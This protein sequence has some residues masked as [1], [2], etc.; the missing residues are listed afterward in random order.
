MVPTIDAFRAKGWYITEK[1]LELIKEQLGQQDGTL[2]DYLRVALDASVPLDLRQLNEAGIPK[3]D[4]SEFPCP[5][6]LQIADVRNVAVPAAHQVEKPRLLRITFTDGKRKFHGVELGPIDLKLHTPPGTK[7][8]VTQPIPIRDQLLLLLPGV[9]QP[10]GGHVQEMIQAW[11][12]GKQFIKRAHENIE[13]PPL[14]V[15]FKIEIKAKEKETAEI[16]QQPKNLPEK[17]LQKHGKKHRKEDTAQHK[18]KEEKAKRSSERD[19]DVHRSNTAS[20]GPQVIKEDQLRS[21]QKT[22][23][24]HKASKPQSKEEQTMP[25]QA[26]VTASMSMSASDRPPSRRKKTSKLITDNDKANNNEKNEPA[27][28]T[29]KNR[30]PKGPKKKEDRATDQRGQ[31]PVHTGENSQ[32]KE[33]KHHLTPREKHPQAGDRKGSKTPRDLSSK[34]KNRETERPNN[35]CSGLENERQ[36]KNAT[37][38]GRPFY[39]NRRGHKPKGDISEHQQKQQH[40]QQPF[41]SRTKQPKK[42]KPS[43]SSNAVSIRS[44]RDK[45]PNPEQ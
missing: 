6:V 3:P 24:K 27:E 26:P 29:G 4:P 31:G 13:G 15:P 45:P 1:G 37:D 36:E 16:K 9:L 19:K 23:Q 25:V 5:A 20:S 11:R 10:L 38:D 41:S 32:H 43:G 17:K 12:A 30:P 21:H 22:R 14:F 34:A 40:Q 28:I 42:Y 33:R 44:D 18:P 2:E 39:K 35:N 7:V 8:L